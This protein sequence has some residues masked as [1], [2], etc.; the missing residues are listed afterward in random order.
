MLLT[1]LLV[2]NSAY[3]VMFLGGEAGLKYIDYSSKVAGKELFSG[4]TLAQK[5][6]LNSALTNYFHRDQSEYYDIRLGYQWADFTTKVTEPDHDTK[7][8]E[9]SGQFRYSG[10]LGYNP[11]HLPV[12]F[13][14]FI[15]SDIPAVYSSGLNPNGLINDNLL[16]GISATGKSNA[17][18]ATFVFEPDK[19]RSRALYG[20]PRLYL[21]YAEYEFKSNNVNARMDTKTRDLALAGLNKENNWLTYRSTTYE[22]RLNLADGYTRQS[23][24]IGHVN[25]AGQRLWASLT[26]WIDV[27]ADGKLSNYV[28]KVQGENFE[29]YDLNFMAIARRQSWEARTFMNYN[30]MFTQRDVRET[31]SVPVYVKGIYG[32]DSN[33]YASVNTQ[34]GREKY[35]TGKSTAASHSN[36]VTLGGSTFNRSSFV[37]APSLIVQTSKDI[38]GNDSYSLDANL[39]TNST[40]RFSRTV[41]LAGKVYWRTKDDGPGGELSQS[42]SSGLGFSSTYH[43][44]TQISYKV[45]GGVEVG[46]GHGYTQGYVSPLPGAVTTSNAP[47]DFM[48]NNLFASALWTPSAEFTTALEVTYASNR[49]SNLPKSD[50][51]AANYRFSYYKGKSFYRFESRY[52]SMIDN[53]KKE[54]FSNQLEVQYMPDIYNEAIVRFKQQYDR[55]YSYNSNNTY[56]LLQKYSYKFFTRDG[57]VRNFATLSQEYSFKSAGLSGLDASGVK[58]EYL[59]I[60]GRYSPTARLSLSGSVRYEKADPGLKTLYYGAGLNADFKLLTTSVDYIYAKRDADNRVE[61]KL[62]ASV[63]RTF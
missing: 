41:G 40:S 48:R 39:E 8:S 54:A 61:K 25:N 7:I 14:A 11:R 60:S 49:V 46:N 6:S 20:L 52:E 19:S 17:S 27:S 58:T 57:L 18:G 34:Q 59:A 24:Q 28:S 44:D 33:W 15:N 5:Y 43:P 10:K 13:S 22:N 50:T 32:A 30:R 35:W 36:S 51:I 2:S 23:I 21:D 38:G 9:S 31:V 56:E 45:G 29:E 26:N 47:P 42:W 16:Y 37:L 4:S 1:V 12:K 55:I 53:A 63:S 3:A 62:G